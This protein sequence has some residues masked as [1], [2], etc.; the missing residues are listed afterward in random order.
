MTLQHLSHRR[1][2]RRVVAGTVTVRQD[3]HL[4]TWSALD[5]SERGIRTVGPLNGLD[6]DKLVDVRVQIGRRHFIARVR[7]RWTSD[8]VHGWEVESIRPPS[9][10]QLAGILVETRGRGA[11]DRRSLR[12]ARFGR[13]LGGVS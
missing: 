3:D 12:S 6:P 1:F 7:H 11:R 4:G 2:V 10:S 9:V 8:D 5:L 13:L